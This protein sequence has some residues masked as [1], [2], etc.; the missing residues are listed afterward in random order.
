MKTATYF[1]DS[2]VFKAMAYGD[3]TKSSVMREKADIVIVGHTVVK[4]GMMIK[5]P[6]EVTSQQ[7]ADMKAA[8]VGIIVTAPT[9]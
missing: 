8:F 1:F 4:H 3:T 6:Y 7:I 2:E 9:L 5:T